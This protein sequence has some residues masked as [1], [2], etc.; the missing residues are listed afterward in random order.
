MLKERIDE[1]WIGGWKGGRIDGWMVHNS[2]NLRM[3]ETMGY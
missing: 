2:K 1:R 3:S